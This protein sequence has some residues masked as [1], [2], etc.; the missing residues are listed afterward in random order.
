MIYIFFGSIAFSGSTITFYYH[1]IWTSYFLLASFGGFALDH[2]FLLPGCPWLL[3]PL[4]ARWPNPFC[5]WVNYAQ[6]LPPIDYLIY[7]IGLVFVLSYYLIIILTRIPTTTPISTRISIP[8]PIHTNLKKP[9][10]MPLH[11]R[12]KTTLVLIPLCNI[13]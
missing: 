13:I 11:N 1:Y 6:P 3:V 9:Q 4:P 10:T 12:G 7:S 5:P 2:Y 8:T